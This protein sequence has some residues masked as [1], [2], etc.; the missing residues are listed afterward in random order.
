MDHRGSVVTV[1]LDTKLKLD[2]SMT[3]HS[4]GTTGGSTVS[5]KVA[6][7]GAMA[8]LG[9]S[10]S[11]LFWII[12]V[13]TFW[14]DRFSEAELAALVSA[15]T[16]LLTVMVSLVVGYLLPENQHVPPTYPASYPIPM[17]PPP[18]IPPSPPLPT[19]PE[20]RST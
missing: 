12:A 15:T 11:T 14:E 2:N 8:T 1:A 5:I 18:P 7:G 3:V 16:G 6:G 19:D 9:A 20:D 10:A 17:P 4:N 13:N